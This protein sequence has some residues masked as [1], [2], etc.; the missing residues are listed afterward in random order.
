MTARRAAAV[1]DFANYESTTIS[2][3]TL[4]EL[5]DC[6]AQERG[7]RDLQKPAAQ[8][9]PGVMLECWSRGVLIYAKITRS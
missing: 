8:A 7:A 2:K 9:T 4:C 1:F 5:Q 3:K 6:E